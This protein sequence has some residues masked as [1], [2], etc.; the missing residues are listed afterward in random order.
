[1]SQYNPRTVFR[2]TSNLLLREFFETKGHQLGVEWEQL[3]E[4]QIQGVYD[5]F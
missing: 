5:A 2:Q 1:M 4:T 3:R